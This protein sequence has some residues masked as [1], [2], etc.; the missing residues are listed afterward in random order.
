M[1]KQQSSSSSLFKASE[2]PIHSQLP[3]FSFDESYLR[4]FRYAIEP[5]KLDAENKLHEMASDS[6]NLLTDLALFVQY[7]TLGKLMPSD[8]LAGFPHYAPAM[9]SLSS[10]LRI[11]EFSP[12]TYQVIRSF[13]LLAAT[14]S[15]T[16]NTNP[17]INLSRV[18]NGWVPTYAGFDYY[19]CD[20]SGQTKSFYHPS[21]GLT[22]NYKNYTLA[23]ANFFDF[24]SLV[25]IN[26]RYFADVGRMLDPEMFNPI[27][28]RYSVPKE[29]RTADPSS[30]TYKPKVTNLFMITYG[31]LSFVG[32]FESI[33]YER[34][35]YSFK[36]N[37]SFKALALEKVDF[38]P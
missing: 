9:S 23:Y 19:N 33:S 18:H 11:V 31:C 37:F 6:T 1:P 12:Y 26:G 28:K 34:M 13:I 22:N 36:F 7:P 21:V 16:I 5:D 35:P 8:E 2:S 15:M 10:S 17:N 24:I 4:S 3:G 25:R 29:E 27:A 32:Y 20:F 38:T 14:D 30:L